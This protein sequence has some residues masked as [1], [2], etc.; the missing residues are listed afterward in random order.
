MNQKIFLASLFEAD[1]LRITLAF[2]EKEAA[3][4]RCK[5]WIECYKRNSSKKYT[6]IEIESPLYFAYAK[7][8]KGPRIEVTRTDLK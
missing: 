1:Q 3:T 7:E 6:W 8:R 4:A 2:K 5:Q